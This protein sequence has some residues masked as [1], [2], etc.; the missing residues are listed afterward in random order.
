MAQTTNGMIKRQS[1]RCLLTEAI[2]VKSFK[3]IM[4][5]LMALAATQLLPAAVKPSLAPV[6]WELTF[7]FQD[8]QRVSVFVPGRSEPVVYWYMLYTIENTNEAVA[9]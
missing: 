5:G 2:M 3:I 7:R 1:N 9:T 6:S 4:L 8:P